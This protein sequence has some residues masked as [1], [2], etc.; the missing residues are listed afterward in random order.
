MGLFAVESAHNCLLE[1]IGLRRVF[2]F[3]HAFGQFAQ[4][5]WAEAT[6]LRYLA[7][8]LG[9]LSL[10]LSRQPFD[11]FDDFS[12]CHATSL[13]ALAMRCKLADCSVFPS[14]SAPWCFFSRHAQAEVVHIETL[15]QEGR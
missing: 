4:L 10:F 1:P 3:D 2:S 14:G 9:D 7:G 11:L 12:R 5:L 15:R 13:P 8:E 6:V